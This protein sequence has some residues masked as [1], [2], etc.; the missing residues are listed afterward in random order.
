MLVKN[1]VDGDSWRRWWS[2]AR[3]TPWT[4]KSAHAARD[5]CRCSRS[6][7]FEN[8]SAQKGRTSLRADLRGNIGIHGN[9]CPSWAKKS[10]PSLMTRQSLHRHTLDCT[11]TWLYLT[12]AYGP[13]ALALPSHCPRSSCEFR[14]T[15]SP[16]PHPASMPPDFLLFSLYPRL[17]LLPPSAALRYSN[18]SASFPPLSHL[19]HSALKR[20]Y[21]CTQSSTSH[22]PRL[23]LPTR[24]SISRDWS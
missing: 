15:T 6:H 11:C 8:P 17:S 23:E 13:S 18:H 12:V 16:V 2:S 19:V 14:A 4:S 10:I 20:W 7:V 21:W 1:L 5:G 24:I 3:N 9:S 22:Q